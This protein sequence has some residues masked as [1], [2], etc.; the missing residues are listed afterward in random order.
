MVWPGVFS[1]FGVGTDV[2]TVSRLD[3]VVISV[4]LFRDGIQRRKF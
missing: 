4:I 2:R 3:F 1:D